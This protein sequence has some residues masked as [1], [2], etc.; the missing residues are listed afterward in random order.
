MVSLAIPRA[1]VTLAS[2]A[3]TVCYGQEDKTLTVCCPSGLGNRLRVLLSGWV[4]AE[5]CGRRFRLLWPLTPACGAA[6]SDLFGNPWPVE[7]LPGDAEHGLPFHRDWLH[8]LPDLRGLDTPHLAFV[9]PGWLLDPGRHPG[10]AA[11]LAAA[12][13][14]MGE[15]RPLPALQAAV[16]DFARQNFRERMIGVHLRR[17]DM[18]RLRPDVVGNIQPAMAAVE[19]F[20]RRYPEAG[21]FLCTDDG[22]PTPEG[23][24]TR[25]TGVREQFRQRYGERVVWTTPQSHDRRS[26]AAIQEALVD[27]W[28]LRRT[29]CFVGTE[30]SSFSEFAVFGREHCPTCMVRGHSD[31]YHH[32]ERLA[33]LSG[34]HALLRRLGRRKYGHEVPFT[35][36]FRY[37]FRQAPRDWL[38]ARLRSACPAALPV[39]KRLRT[40]RKPPR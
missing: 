11:L 40:G 4:L 29:D 21:I 9:Y 10:H 2:R 8:A 16:D 1:P 14:L 39:L 3:D 28:L 25:D 13:G 38:K 30:E 35:V 12:R 33:R 20:L 22:A 36:A 27:L 17:G 18:M 37:Y 34:L 15:L 23:D 5:A 6:F 26:A 31:A 19:R 32:W 7:V 24:G